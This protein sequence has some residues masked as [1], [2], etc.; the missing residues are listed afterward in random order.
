[1]TDRQGT[2]GN[3]AAPRAGVPWTLAD[4]RWL[5]VGLLAAVALLGAAWWGAS[6]TGRVVDQ[7][8]WLVVGVAADVLVGVA[9]AWWLLSARQALTR[10]T[11]EAVAWA[12][13]LLPPVAGGGLEQH[14][15]WVPGTVRYH[16]TNCLLVAGRAEVLVASRDQHERGGR[17]ACEVCRP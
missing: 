12:E 8:R 2:S 15:V 3:G 7:V 17:R 13:R 16:R 1:M 14:P 11:Q 9:C 5:F 10:R 6:G 4:A